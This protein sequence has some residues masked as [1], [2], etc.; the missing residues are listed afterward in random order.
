MFINMHAEKLIIYVHAHIIV[1]IE[2][3][4]GSTTYDGCMNLSIVYSYIYNMNV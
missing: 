3:K 1:E 2:S 4:Y